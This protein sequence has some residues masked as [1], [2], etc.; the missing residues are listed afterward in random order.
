MLTS[1]NSAG[2]F[3]QIANEDTPP[4]ASPK[5]ARVYTA[6]MF[7]A[8]ER[9]AQRLSCS[10]RCDWMPVPID[11]SY[12][13]TRSRL[14]LSLLV[15][16][17]CSEL[18]LQVLLPAL[19][20]ATISTCAEAAA[21]LLPPRPPADDSLDVSAYA[22]LSPWYLHN[23]YLIFACLGLSMWNSPIYC[24][25]G[26]G[27]ALNRAAF[28]ALQ[29][30]GPCFKLLLMPSTRLPS[31][32][33]SARDTFIGNFSSSVAYFGL[34]QVVCTCVVAATLAVLSLGLCWR[35][36]RG[37]IYLCGMEKAATTPPT[38]SGRERPPPPHA[39]GGGPITSLVRSFVAQV[40]LVPLRHIVACALSSFALIL[41]SINI[42]ALLQTAL[43]VLDEVRG[44]VRGLSA[45]ADNA[46]VTLRDAVAF[47]PLIVQV[48]AGAL[49]LLQFYSFYPIAKQTLALKQRYKCV[50]AL[51]SAQ[52]A[53]ARAAAAAAGY[54]KGAVAAA[55]AAAA[56]AP[57]PTAA[58]PLLSD[59]QGE[60]DAGLGSK[61]DAFGL[62]ILGATQIEEAELL[63]APDLRRFYFLGAS[64]YI[65]AHTLLQI[66]VCLATAA[67]AALTWVGLVI[68]CGGARN[69]L[70]YLLAAARAHVFMIVAGTVLPYLF[71]YCVGPGL[72]LV[73]L[74]AATV[75]SPLRRV[76]MLLCACASLS[77]GPFVLAPRVLAVVDGLLSITAGAVFGVIDAFTRL[78]LALGWALVKTAL[79]YEPVVP[80]VFAALDA[81][82]MSYG[83]MMRTFFIKEMDYEETGE[84]LPAQPE[85]HQLC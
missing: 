15:I 40:H 41:V 26:C 32:A 60:E 73:G 69:T 62:T 27:F 3:L 36:H 5:L 28:V 79:I 43:T 42:S 25:V 19:G 33:A 44:Q 65:A 66:V 58:T 77:D 49:V 39:A 51:R 53:S 82:F 61:T 11:L 37:E 18:I 59:S 47:T 56:S 4:P 85:G 68:S 1:L 52:P 23:A 78:G 29:E 71:V 16:Q 30:G 70:L 6:P 54:E 14:A 75:C 57:P 83:G 31:G 80:R 8:S 20:F 48:V 74:R 12:Q 38:S 9:A 67:L 81:P 24:L 72:A 13:S 76:F 45:A 64:S 50:E 63:L 34:F 22:L 10:R 35:R 46:L 2:T 55:A 21:S 84:H 17:L 7:S